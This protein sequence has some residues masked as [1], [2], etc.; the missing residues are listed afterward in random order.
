MP[1]RVQ[2]RRDRPWRR[3][4]PDAVLVDRRGNWGNPFRVGIHGTAEECVAAYAR[5]I[6]ANGGGTFAC[7]FPPCPSY[8]DQLNAQMQARDHIHELRGKDL[9]CWCP[10]DQPCHADV[11]L[12]LAN[13]DET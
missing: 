8:A 12:E 3:D 1:E 6:G 9:A 13:R 2:M 7:T 11:L 4:H 5:L 10:L